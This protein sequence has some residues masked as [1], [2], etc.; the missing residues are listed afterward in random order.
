MGP[1]EQSSLAH[2]RYPRAAA[3]DTPRCE[4][5]G[6]LN[7]T[8][9][10]FSDGGQFL[11]MRSALEHARRMLGQGA[12]VIDVGGESSRPAGKSYGAGGASVP[13]EVELDRVIP[14]ITALTRDQRAVVSVDTVKAE[15]ARQAI[16]AGATIVND[17]SCASSTELLEVVA[18]AGAQLVL[19]HNR[20][21]GEIT[22]ENTAYGDVVTD[23]I[24]EL[25]AAVARAVQHGVA[26]ERIWLD[27][28]IGFAKTASQSL[29]L[30]ANT[31]A[32]VATG[33]RVLVGASRKSFIANLA[34]DHGGQS[35]EPLAREGGTAA[36]VSLA[37]L[38][39]AHAV[40]VHD[41]ASMRQAAWIA[42]QAR[43]AR[44]LR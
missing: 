17:V 43:D 5:W 11:Q 16:G 12:S 25:R 34:P 26:A 13:L 1:G 29:A 18:R 38:A 41:V 9:D 7:A 24:A 8:P 4:I 19:M 32:F 40:R 28:G 6:V 36:A 20:G 31:S 10:S 44:T 3:S 30:L 42:E 33:H 27:P 39:G 22:A 14:L 23:V 37:V 2:E 15:V 21:R 35:P